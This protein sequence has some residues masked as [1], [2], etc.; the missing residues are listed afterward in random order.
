M[1]L[2][3][4]HL[5][6]L[7]GVSVNSVVSLQKRI[8]GGHDCDDKERLYHVRLENNDGQRRFH[9]GASLIH[10]EWILTAAHC[11]KSETGWYNIAIS[12]VH[13][14]TAKQQNQ[15]RYSS[16]GRRGRN[17]NRPQ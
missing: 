7:L 14:R 1:A 6:L 9:C 12:K 15:R 4:V 13:P 17:D 16:A 5:L 11:W 2:L 10:P 3:K 8:I